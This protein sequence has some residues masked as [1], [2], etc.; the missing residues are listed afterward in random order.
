MK[1]ILRNHWTGKGGAVAGIG[2]TLALLGTGPAEQPQPEPQEP[3]AIVVEA[4]PQPEPLYVEAMPQPER[5]NPQALPAPRTTKGEVKVSEVERTDPGGRTFVQRNFEVVDSQQEL[6]E[7]Q[8]MVEAWARSTVMDAEVT[9]ERYRE[10]AEAWARSIVE[11]ANATV[12]GYSEAVTDWLADP[13][14]EAT[15]K[16][17]QELHQHVGDAATVI[18]RILER[19]EKEP[20]LVLTALLGYLAS[21]FADPKPQPKPTDETE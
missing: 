1:N 15:T 2:S 21:L 5:I 6:T 17:V 11:E 12:E 7:Y 16:D 14:F 3:P 18:Q 10:E 19:A 20:M 8:R 13:V 9:L 4:A